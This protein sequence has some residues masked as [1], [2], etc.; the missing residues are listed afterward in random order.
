MCRTLISKVFDV[1]VFLD[2]IVIEIIAILTIKK[3]KKRPLS[4]CF[5]FHSIRG[6][7]LLGGFLTIKILKIKTLGKHLPVTVVTK[8]AS[9]SRR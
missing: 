2:G 5:V 7:Q 4:H 3:M 9:S 1:S 6:K 8:T